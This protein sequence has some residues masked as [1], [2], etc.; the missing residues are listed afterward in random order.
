MKLLGGY[1]FCFSII[2]VLRFGFGLL[3]LLVK[4]KNNVQNL[5]S[6]TLKLRT[7]RVLSRIA[8]LASKYDCSNPCSFPYM[9]FFVIFQKILE[10]KK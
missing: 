6:P 5:K 7:V 3:S 8:N 2:S 9:T 1:H 4:L 10:E